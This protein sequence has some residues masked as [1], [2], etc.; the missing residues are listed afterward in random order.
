MKRKFKSFQHTYGNITD[1]NEKHRTPKLSSCWTAFSS[2][3]AGLNPPLWQNR[4]LNGLKLFQ[5]YQ[6]PLHTVS[7]FLKKLNC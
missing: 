2:L 4:K 6:Y 3:E 5:S 7:K 1:F